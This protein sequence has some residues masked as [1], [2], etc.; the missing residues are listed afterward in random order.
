MIIVILEITSEPE[1]RLNI[2]Q[3]IHSV[4]GPTSAQSGCQRCGLYSSTHND[5]ELLL[6]QKWDSQESLE[7]HIRSSEY[8][9]ILTAMDSASQPPVI[10]FNEVKTSRGFEFVEKTLK[11]QHYLA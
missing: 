9:K 8:R 5:D 4:I 1:K 10:T 3:T 7:K 6:L 2:I 11:N